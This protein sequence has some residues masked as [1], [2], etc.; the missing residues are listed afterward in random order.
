M[1]PKKKNLQKRKNTQPP[2]FVEDRE[3]GRERLGVGDWRYAICMYSLGGCEK[4]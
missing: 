2:G 1:M 3:S 4:M